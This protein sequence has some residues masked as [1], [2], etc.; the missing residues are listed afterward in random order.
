M[1]VPYVIH[2]TEPR[3]KKEA[4]KGIVSRPVLLPVTTSWTV[5][6]L[7][8]IIHCERGP[9]PRTGPSGEA[10]LTRGQEPWELESTGEKSQVIQGS[11]MNSQHGSLVA[12]WVTAFDNPQACKGEASFGFPKLPRFAR[13]HKAAEQ[14]QASKKIRLSIKDPKSLTCRKSQLQDPSFPKKPRTWDHGSRKPM[15][16]ARDERST[17]RSHWLLKPALT[18]QPSHQFTRNLFSARDPATTGEWSKRKYH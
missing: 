18:L 15:T 9:G 2:F 5:L 7:M 16:A 4:K 11:R 1:S 8:Q 17:I 10:I 12:T 6:D 13:S 3:K 14:M